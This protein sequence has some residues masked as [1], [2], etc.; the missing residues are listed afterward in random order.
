MSH[1]T[2]ENQYGACECEVA[3]FVP[4]LDTSCSIKE[5][6]II[7][8]LYRKPSDRNKYLLP[9]SCHP[10]TVKDNIPLSLAMRIT[11]ICSETTSRDKRYEELKNMLLD[12][13]YP[14]RMIESAIKCARNVPRSEAI[15][16]VVRDTTTRRPVFVATWD[17]RLPSLSP[18]LNKH[19]RT[20]VMMDPYLKEVF[21]EP[22][23]VAFKRTKNI[24]DFVIR[25][26]VPPKLNV[27]PE[28]KIP[29]MK[30]CKKGCHLC[31]YILE[32]KIIKTDSFTWKINKTMNCE[33][34]NVVYMIKCQK[35]NNC[36]IGETERMLKERISEHKGYI[37]NN[38]AKEPVGAH[39]NSPGHDL[40]DLKVI[41][42]EKVKSTNTQYRK[43]RESYLIRKFNAF[44]KGINKSP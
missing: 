23:L 42:L 3:K 22:P 44:Y 1:T 43:E 37:R 6:K 28:R 32:E 19:W 18:I 12:R 7:L 16:N 15:K 10:Q 5:G 35:C 24:K 13:N 26:K 11:R 29:G 4:F 39:F 34:D 17:P 30:K 38:N 20:M 27:R 9:D 25:A 2:P 33:T 14:R 40:S 21:P 41:I 36:Y 8:D 31:P